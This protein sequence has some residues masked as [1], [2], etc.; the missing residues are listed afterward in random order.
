MA[1]I[2]A[3]AL[4]GGP[5]VAGT[6]ADTVVRHTTAGAAIAGRA[7]IAR[8]QLGHGWRATAAPARVPP[9][10][11]PGFDPHV[12]AAVEIGAATTGRLFQTAAGPFVSQTAYAYA[13]AAEATA[14]ARHY[15]RRGLVTC[16]ASSLTGGSTRQVKF[17][18]RR[19]HG[20]AVPRL[21]LAARGYRVAGTATEPEQT[22]A[23]YLDAI[24]LAR[25]QVVTE[26]S[27][28]SFYAPPRRLELRLERLA[29]RRLA[30]L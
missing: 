16:I 29:A 26:L 8:R 30:H 7:L 21:G 3:V 20:L 1:A 15:L 12:P 24:V 23:V 11:C 13:T 17:R 27:L 10:T 28:A 22:V 25:G 19:R 5:Q 2:V 18:V 4:L 6:R 9:I 14:V